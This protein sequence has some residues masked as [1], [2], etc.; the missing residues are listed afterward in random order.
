VIDFG[1][2]HDNYRSKK[3]ALSIPAQTDESNVIDSAT[4]RST[5][6]LL[7]SIPNVPCLKRHEIN[8]I[9]HA[10]KKI[11]GKIKTRSESGIA[12]TDRR[13]PSDNCVNGWFGTR[14][15]GAFRPAKPV[16]MRPRRVRIT[17]WTLHGIKASPVCV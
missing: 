9:Y 13:S 10:V 7:Q 5:S 8:A 17:R 3:D 11:R 6:E 12:I 4:K 14:R 2:L 16:M 1:E 15:R